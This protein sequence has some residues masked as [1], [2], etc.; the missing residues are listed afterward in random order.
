MKWVGKGHP[1]E[2]L[3]PSQ[4]THLLSLITLPQ[5][6]SFIPGSMFTSRSSI[7]CSRGRDLKDHLIQ[8]ISQVRKWRSKEDKVPQLMHGRSPNS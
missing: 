5:L 6:E 7:Q 1:T 3:L 8:P 2:H 4:L